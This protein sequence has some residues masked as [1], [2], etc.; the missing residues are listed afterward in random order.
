MVLMRFQQKVAIVTGSGRGIGEE[1]AFR[2][3]FEGAKVVLNDINTNALDGALKRLRGKSLQAVGVQA[4]VSKES[5]CVSLIE[6]TLETYHKIDILVNNAGIMNVKNLLEETEE[7][8]QRAYDNILK[9]TFFCSRGA[10]RVMVKQRYGRIINIASRAVLGRIGRGGYAAAK[11]GVIG[12]SRTLALE[13][14]PYQITVNCISPAIIDTELS[15]KSTPEGSPE[16]VK[17]VS[18]IPLGRIGKPEDVA[19]AVLFFASDEA[20]WITGQNLFVCG[21]MSLWSSAYF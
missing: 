1:I 4:D 9:S 16:R 6:R 2:L 19:H 8:L 3:A 13:L 7:G 11:A 5:E 10:A 12:L 15:R 20:N 14:A 21:G 18:G 17:L